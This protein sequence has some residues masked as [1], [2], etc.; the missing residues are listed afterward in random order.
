M[1]RMQPICG[2]KEIRKLAFESLYGSQFKLISCRLHLPSLLLICCVNQVVPM[3]TRQV[4]QIKQGDL[5]PL[6]FKGQVTERAC[7]CKM[8]YKLL[9]WGLFAIT[10]LYQLKRLSRGEEIENV[11]MLLALG[12]F[13]RCFIC[14]AKD[15]KAHTNDSTETNLSRARLCQRR[16][17]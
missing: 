12:Y 17:P 4:Y 1:Y 11:A 5:L 15:K 10:Y 8:V 2:R 14:L 9:Q 6:L 7:N 13:S 16:M 3:L